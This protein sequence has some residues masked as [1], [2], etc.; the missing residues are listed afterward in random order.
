[1]LNR[2]YSP[3]GG[4]PVCFTELGYLSPEGFTTPLPGNFA[5]AQNTSVAEHTAW[6]AG[7]ATAASQS[8]KVR[9]MIIWNVDFPFFTADDPMGGY[10]LFRPDGSCPGCDSLGAVM[11][12]G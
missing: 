11:K 6:L 5:W 4:K 7:A 1:M 8:G 12:G 2:G 3:F 9:L 10:A